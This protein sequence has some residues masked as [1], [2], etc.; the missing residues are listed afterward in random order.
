MRKSIVAMVIGTL[1][2]VA[3]LAQAEEKPV[4]G[5]DDRKAACDQ[6]RAQEDLKNCARRPRRKPRRN[7]PPR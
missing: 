3:N 6:Y 2:M 7:R 4:W 5:K 1:F